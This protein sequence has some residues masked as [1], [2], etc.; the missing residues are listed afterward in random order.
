MDLKVC[1]LL[2]KVYI[3]VNLNEAVRNGYTLERVATVTQICGH[4]RTVNKHVIGEG[5]D[6]PPASLFKFLLTLSVWQV[7]HAQ[8]YQI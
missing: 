4:Q 8:T 3:F 2:V 7:S 5:F 6:S 1:A